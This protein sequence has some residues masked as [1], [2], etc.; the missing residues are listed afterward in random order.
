MRIV[1]VGTTVG[2]VFLA[3][4]LLGSPIAS[5]A[6]TRPARVTKGMPHVAGTAGA[7]VTRR[8]AGAPVSY[9]YVSGYQ[10]AA[11]TGASV[12]L[13]QVKPA[14][15]AGDYHSLAELAVESADGRQ[16]VEVGWNADP[17]L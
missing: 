12:T 5:Q 7:N 4:G 14:V 15:S 17:G 2:A 8:A 3:V 1:K 10:Y 9:L 6:T 13:Q 16:I 11:A